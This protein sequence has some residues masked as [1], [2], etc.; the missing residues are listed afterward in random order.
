MRYLPGIS[1]FRKL[2]QKKLEFQSSLG[3]IVDD[4]DGGDEK[5]Q[6]FTLSFDI[7]L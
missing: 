1:A 3:Y 5:G 4:D 2:K 6:K 7:N